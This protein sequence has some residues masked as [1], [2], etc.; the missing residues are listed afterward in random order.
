[1]TSTM[2]ARCG[3]RKHG[4]ACEGVSREPGG[5]SRAASGPSYAVE[6]LAF[7]AQR[8]ELWIVTPPTMRQILT[9]TLLLV[10]AVLRVDA[11]DFPKEIAPILKEHCYE[12]HSEARKKE[13][14]GFVFD[15]LKRFAKDIGPNL[16]IEPGNPGESHFFE[17]IVD[18]SVK[19]HMPPKGK[20][21]Q[22]KI[23]KIRAWI[24]EGANFDPNAKKMVEKKTLPP[25][26]RW[27]NAEGK[28]IKAGFERLEGDSV[29]LKMPDGK[30][31]K[32]PLAKLS[33]ES[34]QLAKECA[35]E[36]K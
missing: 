32:Y 15:N 34:K 23:D 17:V 30:F 28:A 4:P 18:D 5:A 20:L 25:I 26:M 24:A 12:C 14:A 29:V 1:M 33:P 10:S 27:T 35:V 9:S 2:I 6:G 13:K 19:H 16:N 31:V 22:E 8:R 3:L 36:F 7:F 21:P 11:V